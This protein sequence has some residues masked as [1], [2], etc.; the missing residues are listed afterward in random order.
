[1]KDKDTIK[2]KKD[3]GAHCSCKGLELKLCK[4]DN[5]V[6]SKAQYVFSKR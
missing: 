6:K 1:M 2:S 4:N 3:L 5:V